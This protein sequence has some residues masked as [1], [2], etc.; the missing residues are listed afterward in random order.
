MGFHK[1][2]GKFN[3][4]SQKDDH[5]YC[6]DS[7][8]ASE[9]E[10]QQSGKSV[11]S[12]ADHLEP[13]SLSGGLFQPAADDKRK[14][15]IRGH[16]VAGLHIK[17]CNRHEEKQRRKQDTQAYAQGKMIRNSDQILENPGEEVCRVPD[18]K[19][20]SNRAGTNQLSAE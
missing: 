4:R 5:E 3:S 12:V 18:Q 10:P 15:V 6:G 14:A 9:G 1:F 11:Q 20:I 7:G 17:S 8:S 16:T 2:A 19:H 13:V